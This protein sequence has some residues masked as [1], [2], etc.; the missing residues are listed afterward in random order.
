MRR[1]LERHGEHF[2]NKVLTPDEQHFC[3]A[4]RDTGLALAGRFAVKEAAIKA[5]GTP[6]G[7]R[8]RDFE[9][10]P[11]T[12]NSPPNLQLHGAVAAHAQKR[13]IESLNVS[14]TH[15]AGIAAAVVIAEGIVPIKKDS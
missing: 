3:Q 7:A 2:M 8:W 9:V 13:G 1:V 5:I 15:D 14:I 10:I 11:A 6:Q 12:L 4:R